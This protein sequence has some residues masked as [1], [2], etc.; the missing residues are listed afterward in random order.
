MRRQTAE[1]CRD[2]EIVSSVRQ[3]YERFPYPAVERIEQEDTERNLRASFNVDLGLRG[4]AALRPGATVW[5]P[6]CGTRW[7]VMV[8]LQFR[9]VQVLATDLSQGSLSTQ[10]ALARAVGVTNIEFRYEDLLEA[11]YQ[12]QFDYISCVGVLHHLPDP[13]AGFAVVARALKPT[14]LAEIMVYDRWNRHYSM[15]MQSVLAVLDPQ[16]RLDA[17]ARFEVATAVLRSRTGLMNTPREV[18]RVLRLLDRDPAFAI[19]LADFI[20]H[21]QEHYFD[22]PSLVGVLGRCGLMVHRWKQAH[23]FDPSLMNSDDALRRQLDGLDEVS[24]AHLG[25]L[26]S[27]ALL[28]VFVRPAEHRPD[29]PREDMR[30]RTVRALTHRTVHHIS[31]GGDLIRSDRRAIMMRRDGRLLFDG[32]ERRPAVAAYGM[33]RDCIRPGPRHLQRVTD[34]GFS[35][36]LDDQHIE[37]I[38]RAARV[39]TEI[40]RIA[41]V[42]SQ[43]SS[44]PP[45]EPHQVVQMCEQLCRSPFRL[46]ATV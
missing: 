21:P 19:E 34:F 18:T 32:G 13:A 15:R 43:D 24:R 35:S 33:D 5:V 26:F 38:V 4:A 10:S 46:L 25:H 8:A 9:D 20:S 37:A 39:P 40:G 44:L 42:V 41:D 1:H 14:G 22:V 3:H 30:T 36:S 29:R 31:A 6:G 45:A 17:K 2:D 28:E 27:T 11:P 16:R 23:L 7:A 12:A